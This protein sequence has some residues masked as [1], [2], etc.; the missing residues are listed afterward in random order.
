MFPFAFF[1]K[2]G[3]ASPQLRCV[4]S[5]KQYRVRLAVAAML[6]IV[7]SW[8]SAAFSAPK[9]LEPAAISS[10]S[11]KYK[12]NVEWEDIG[13]IGVIRMNIFHPNGDPHFSLELPEISPSPANL[14][15][16]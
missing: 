5:T 4:S 15:W 8:T 3:A 14:M 7:G 1:W 13:F 10:P 9:V 6:G 11:R 12:A 16:I 2:W